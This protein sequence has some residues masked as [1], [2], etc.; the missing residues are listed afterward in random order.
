VLLLGKS[1]GRDSPRGH[2]LSHWALAPSVTADHEIILEIVRA[3]GR[4][5]FHTERS[6]FP[7]TFVEGT[8]A[9]ALNAGSSAAAVQ[10]AVHASQQVGSRRLSTHQ[11]SNERFPRAAPDVVLCWR[12][13]KEVRWRNVP[14]PRSRDVRRNDRKCFPKKRHDSSRSHGHWSREPVDIKQ[15]LPPHKPPT[16]SNR[17]HVFGQTDEQCP[18]SSS[19]PP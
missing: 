1:C 13:S 18:N 4:R 2:S 17:R 6:R 3:T 5:A 11:L 8:V 12:S 7:E 15:S 9:G 19:L 10:V 14:R 16:A